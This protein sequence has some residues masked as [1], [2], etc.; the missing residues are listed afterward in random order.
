MGDLANWP[1]VTVPEVWFRPRGVWISWMEVSL[2]RDAWVSRKT[3]R[4]DSRV[5]LMGWLMKPDF[6]G[7]ANGSRALTFP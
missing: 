6:M 7:K 2:C 1:G 5:V 4:R 3:S